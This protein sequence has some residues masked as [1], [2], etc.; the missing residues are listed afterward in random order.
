MTGQLIQLSSFAFELS[1]HHPATEVN[2]ELD[3]L[4]M[5]LKYDSEKLATTEMMYYDYL[6]N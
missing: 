5:W 2:R 3:S 4:T 6:Y 1:Y